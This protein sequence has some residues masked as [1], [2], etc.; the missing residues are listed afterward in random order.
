MINSGPIGYYMYELQSTE[1]PI[2]MN[3]FRRQSTSVETTKTPGTKG[4]IRLQKEYG[5]R[6]VKVRYYK[7]S[8]TGETKRTIELSID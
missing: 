5:D 4:T 2:Y 1:D 3:F 6:L 7:D 8:K